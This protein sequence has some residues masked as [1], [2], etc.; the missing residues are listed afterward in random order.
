[1]VCAA[2]FGFSYGHVLNL[3]DLPWAVT[4]IQYCIGGT[5]IIVKI[6]DQISTNVFGQS[7]KHVAKEYDL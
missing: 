4:H 6:L 7:F 2:C 1:M 3:W 5:L